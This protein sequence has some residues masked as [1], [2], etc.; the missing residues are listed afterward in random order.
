MRS[1]WLFYFVFPGNAQHNALTAFLIAIG[2]IFRRFMWNFFH[3]EKEHMSN[4]RRFIASRDVPLP[5]SIPDD[6]L[7]RDATLEAQLDY[8]RTDERRTGRE[9]NRAAYEV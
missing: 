3:M 5:F 6:R 4:A 8:S 9:R 1:S 7:N 2:E